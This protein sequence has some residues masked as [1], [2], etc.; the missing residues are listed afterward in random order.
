MSFKWFLSAVVMDVYGSFHTPYSG[1]RQH[2]ENGRGWPRNRQ[3]STAPFKAE[4]IPLNAKF[5]LTVIKLSHIWN[6]NYNRMLNLLKEI[7]WGKS[8]QRCL[9][10]FEP[11]ILVENMGGTQSPWTTECQGEN[12]IHVVSSA[13]RGA[14]NW[15]TRGREGWSQEMTVWSLKK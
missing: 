2:W 6:E 13:L 11:Q 3:N 14:E 15:G 9:H 7:A 10:N 12:M 8:R 4:F 5:L 1:I